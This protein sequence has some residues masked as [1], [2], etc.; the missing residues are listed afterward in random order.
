MLN[1]TDIPRL[2]RSASRLAE[3]ARVLAK[4]GLAGALA[5]LDYR[6]VRRWTAGTELHRLADRP[7]EVR[8]R[9][10]LTE[11]GTT[12]I[13]FGQVLSTRRDL[14]GPALGDELATLQSHVP[15]DPFSVTR[16]TVETELRQPLEVLFAAFEPEPLASASIGQVHRAVLRDGRKVAVKVQHPGITHRVENDLAILAELAALAEE[17]LPEFKAYRPVA[18][19]AE[20]ERVL[21]RELDFRRELRHLQLFRQAF[22]HDP[23]VRFPEPHPSL[24]SGRVLTMELF[25]GVPFN[26]P[27]EVRAAGGDFEALARAGAKAFLDMIFRDGLFHADPHPGNLLFL[28]P[29]GNRPAAIGL[30]DVGMV[31]RIDERLRATIDRGVG[32][33]LVKDAATVTELIVQAGDVPAGFDAGALEGEVADQLAFYH[34]MPLEQFELGTALNEL[35]DAIRRYHVMLPAPV[36]LLLRVLVMLEGTGRLLAPGFNLLE[37]LDPY[38]QASVRK[39]LSPR[40]LLRRFV[41][42]VGEWDD[43]VRGLP[44]QL[45]G[46]MRMVQRREVGVELSHRHLEPSVN[47]LVFGM[48]VSAL[49]V[50]SALL[51]AFKAEPLVRDV[52][53]FGLLG[54][55]VSA[56]LGYRLFRAIQHS[57]KLEERDRHE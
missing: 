1:L 31:G 36:A 24:S 34:G 41:G 45:S 48:M 37:L 42:A 55:V 30:I 51:W 15:A 44:R 17:Y 47:R 11:L 21:T 49:F 8:V 14:I 19:V 33:V 29:V 27:D 40:R 10:V 2:A 54:C 39:K 38:K 18:V 9:L 43:L 25:E 28:P 50:G 5:R 57:G 46:V 12:F 56:L 35:T 13:K 32:A 53:V 16:A 22:A 52:S 7:W 20:F 6:F 23:G 3:I 4:Y 26:R